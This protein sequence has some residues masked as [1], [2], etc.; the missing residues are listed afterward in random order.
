MNSN[1]FT[2]LIITAGLVAIMYLANSL[3]G[4]FR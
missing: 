2:F 4:A 1:L 3:V